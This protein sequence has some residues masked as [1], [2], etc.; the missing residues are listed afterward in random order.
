MA[1]LLRECEGKNYSNVSQS[2]WLCANATTI[3][4][5]YRMFYLNMSLC[6]NLYLNNCKRYEDQ[7]I[8]LKTSDLKF[9]QPKFELKNQ[10]NKRFIKLFTNV[11]YTSPWLH[12]THRNCIPFLA[13]LEQAYRDRWFSRPQLSHSSDHPLTLEEEER[14]PSLLHSL[15]EKVTRR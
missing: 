6:D 3:K 1:Y 14:R 11:Q 10:R 9:T 2:L 7:T 15:R 8:F 12:G 4:K 5:L 13:K